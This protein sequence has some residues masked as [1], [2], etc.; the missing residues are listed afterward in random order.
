MILHFSLTI[1]RQTVGLD[2][3][4]LTRVVNNAFLRITRR[5]AI[6]LVP[7]PVTG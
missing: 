7:L 6:E 1:Q 3:I 4:F 2:R 5:L